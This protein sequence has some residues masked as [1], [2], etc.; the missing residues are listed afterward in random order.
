MYVKTSFQIEGV[1][2]DPE[3]LMSVYSIA[4]NTVPTRAS[5]TF[6]GIS[7]DVVIIDHLFISSQVAFVK[8]S[9]ILMTKGQEENTS[10][11]DTLFVWD[12]ILVT[13]EE[14]SNNNNNNN[15]KAT[16]TTVEWEGTWVGVDNEDATKVEAPKRGAFDELV[17]SDMHFQVSG[18]AHEQEDGSILVSVTQGSGWDLKDDTKK[19]SDIKHDLYLE[20]LKWTGAVGGDQTPNLIFSEGEN[21]EFGKFIG[22]GWMRPGNRMTVA[23]RY[24]ADKDERTLDTVKKIVWEEVC[25]DNDKTRIPPWQCTVMNTEWNSKKRSREEQEGADEQDEGEKKAKES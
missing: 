23:R 12:G 24:L 16:T 19:H 10:W 25:G 2:E 8:I 6:C 3:S 22:V 17:A 7:L 13:K 1:K 18:T 20:S 11:R 5:L 14:T 9:I 4:H 15:N 21:G